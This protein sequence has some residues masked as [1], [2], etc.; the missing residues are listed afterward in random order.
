MKKAGGIVLAVILGVGLHLGAMLFGGLLFNHKK[1]GTT[2]VE[3]IDIAPVEEEKK[4]EKPEEEKPK[5]EKIEESEDVPEFKNLAQID[6]PSAPALAPMSLAD[7]E[8]ALSGLGGDSGFGGA[9]GITSGGV[10]GGT[11]SGMGDGEGGGML[12]AGQLDQRPKLV[13]KVDPQPPAALRKTMGTVSVTVYIDSSGRVSKVSVTPAIDPS[14]ERII[15]EAVRKWRYEP[16]LREGKRVGC[17]V[18]HR[19]SFST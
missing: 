15:V 8:S 13:F 14:A 16:G 4:V 1:A 9:G 18:S 6:Q 12:S 17:K 7:L 11:G 10:I 3:K 5:E 19:L 2:T